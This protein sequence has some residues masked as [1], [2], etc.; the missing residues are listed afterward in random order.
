MTKYPAGLIK[1]A[2]PWGGVPYGVPW[3]NISQWAASIEHWAAYYRVPEWVIIAIIVIESQGDESAYRPGDSY[4]QW[5]AT[6]LMQV[7][8]HYWRSLIIGPASATDADAIAYLRRGDNAIQLGAAVMA[9]GIKR[10]EIGR[11]HV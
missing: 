6:G 4:D 2:S 1:T 8:A 10:F 11:A 3:R 5:P 9:D 7:K